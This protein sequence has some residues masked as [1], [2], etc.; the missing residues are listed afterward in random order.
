[1]LDAA[2]NS[3]A[4]IKLADTKTIERF[5]RRVQSN[6]NYQFIQNLISASRLPGSP[7]SCLSNNVNDDSDSQ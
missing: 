1:M 2:E 7:R 5:A 6:C 4:G 3:F